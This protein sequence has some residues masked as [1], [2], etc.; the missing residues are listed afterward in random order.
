MTNKECRN[1]RREIDES[2]LGHRPS[3]RATAHMAGCAGCQAFQAERTSLRDWLVRPRW[4]ER[5][6]L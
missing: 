2:E 1:T 6:C 3:A 5:H 4:P